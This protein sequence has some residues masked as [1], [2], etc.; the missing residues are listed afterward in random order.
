MK[1]KNHKQLGEIGERIAIGELSKFGIDI[2]LPMSDNL[3]FDFLAYINNKF[4]K[5]QVKTTKVKTTN[6]SYKF[7]LTSNN[8][9]KKTQYIYNSNDYDVLICCNL[10][11]IFLFKFLDIKGRKNICIQVEQTKNKQTKGVNFAKDSIISEERIKYV[12]D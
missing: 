1:M 6:N 7:S 12:F 8:W 4:Y 9:N 5:C 11:T 2:L 10:E 3:A